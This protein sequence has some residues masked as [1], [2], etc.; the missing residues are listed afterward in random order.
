M[1]LPIPAN[2]QQLFDAYFPDDEVT[3]ENEVEQVTEAPEQ[4]YDSNN[5]YEDNYYRTNS[6]A[7]MQA[8]QLNEVPI[9]TANLNISV[10]KKSI[11]VGQPFQIK[12][13]L[14]GAEPYSAPDTS[15]LPSELK[16]QTQSQQSKVSIINGVASKS[17]I[18]MV[19]VIAQS[20]GAYSI[21][22]VS[23]QTDIGT[24]YSDSLNLFAK[25]AGELPTNTD[26]GSVFIEASVD[27][28]DPYV[29]EPIE[30]KVKIMHLNAI[31]QPELMKPKSDDALIEQ[32]TEP[33][34]RKENINGKIYNVSEVSYL[35]TP[36]I[37]GKVKLEPSILRG[38]ILKEVKRE[39]P[40]T[41][42]DDFFDPFSVIGGAGI[43]V[44]REVESFAIASNNIN[45]VVQDKVA[46]VDPWLA[47]YDLQIEDELSELKAN[48]DNQITTMVGEPIS[49]K[50]VL[51]AIGKKGKDLP[52]IENFL[53]AEGFK[54]YSDKPEFE[55]KILTQIEGNIAKKIK[56]IKTQS[57][58]FIPEKAGEII[59]PELK[60][61]YFSIPEK[62]VKYSILPSKKVNVKPSE[63][64][65]S[66]SSNIP[67]VAS[68]ENL[69]QSEEPISN[70]SYIII[71]LLLTLILLI[72][73]FI[74]RISS[75]KQVK[76]IASVGTE[77]VLKTDNT[78]SRKIID[79]PI[80]AAVSIKPDSK[81]KIYSIVEKIKAA[82][83]FK[84]IEAIIKLYTNENFNMPET[85]SL[86]IT[87]Q[88]LSRK[89]KLNK[90]EFVSICTDIDS[91]IYSRKKLDLADSR[92]RLARVFTSLEEKLGKNK[93]NDLQPLNPR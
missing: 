82:N 63:G 65:V 15:I 81:D 79:S 53:Q 39:R 75:V 50:I 61:A 5:N 3:E 48:D 20:T 14:N 9:P 31:E 19:E 38:Q 86:T 58:T 51:T 8:Q 55:Q 6:P 30:Y 13:E 49:R 70:I 92:V 88:Q 29:G 32:L 89:Y 16:I 91:A 69:E 67:Q 80:V 57:F 52:D 11:A 60:I 77:K 22:P 85:N 40:R 62:K 34:R 7:S 68:Q 90:A 43:S 27:K 56:G 10:N 74:Y 71:I 18:W 4:V 35:V 44:T 2:S 87:A 17:T 83:S 42:F 23:I 25:D 93:S 72:L 12:I 73:Y 33:T 1:S 66:I 59:I 84:E 47:L 46:E 41:A 24:I 37:S 54:V 28:K 36:N 26:D 21:P 64:G 45:L 78:T 76:K